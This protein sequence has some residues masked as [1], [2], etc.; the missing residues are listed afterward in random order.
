MPTR[1][2]AVPTI[3]ISYRR[4]DA[5]AYAGRISDHLQRRFG[6]DT[7]FIDVDNIPLGS[8][9][10]QVLDERLH[11]CT[12]FLP[13]IGRHWLTATD[14][15]G[16]RRLDDPKDFVRAE[17][18]T[19]LTRPEIFMIPVLVQGAAVPAARD[20]PPDLQDLVRR[21]ALEIRDDRFLADIAPLIR[22]IERQLAADKGVSTP[23]VEIPAP[24]PR[25]MPPDESWRT[26][27]LA[28]AA[29]RRRQVAEHLSRAETAIAAGE[30]EAATAACEDA[31]LIDP[32]DQRLHEVMARTRAAAASQAITTWLANA[33]RSLS[34][35]DLAAAS[36]ALDEV[37][38]RDAANAEA[39]TLR[40]Q[41]FQARR[42]RESTRQRD[43][44]IQPLLDGAR[45]SFEQGKFAEA[46]ALADEIL[47]VAGNHAAAIELRA[48]AESA[49]LKERTRIAE[50]ERTSKEVTKPAAAAVPLPRGVPAAI[51]PVSKRK[52]I[53]IA[54]LVAGVVLFVYFLGGPTARGVAAVGTWYFSL[55]DKLAVFLGETAGDLFTLEESTTMG[56]TT[57]L[58]SAGFL[59][60]AFSALCAVGLAL[61]GILS[62]L[63]RAL[64]E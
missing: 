26:T 50:E 3:F 44:V 17:I 53:A 6:E 8:N 48:R 25:E 34:A 27:I 39:A 7:V 16:A 37:L 55:I 36:D 62:V 10:D 14:D 61:T 45:V 60:K 63:E 4:D 57:I 24:V 23:P 12:V 58:K 64:K 30:Y 31:A 33:K 56:I 28:A 54:A 32:E 29:K 47:T 2:P 51:E 22:F 18:A 46:M 41:L 42:E 49:E 21:Q 11:T 13:I 5:S 52:V 40:Q 43:R 15:T 1:L 20:L 19:A 35:G 38:A 9:F 59:L